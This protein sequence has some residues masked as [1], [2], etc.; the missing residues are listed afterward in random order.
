MD[1]QRLRALLQSFSGNAATDTRAVAP[2][3]ILV[4][5]GTI[6]R[7]EIQDANR[8]GIW[9]GIATQAF[10]AAIT[11]FFIGHF[12]VRRL[13]RGLWLRVLVVTIYF[14]LVEATRGVV[15][16]YLATT[17]EPY[18]EPNWPYAIVAGGV[19]GIVLFG[20][21]S[22]ILNDA[23]DY[24]DRLAQIL[25]VRSQ[26]E[27][28][29][30]NSQAAIQTKRLELSSRITSAIEDALQKV[31]SMAKPSKE[32]AMSFAN[33][34]I[35]I[36][37]EVVRPL[38]HQ[39][40]QG[41]GLPEITS[42]Q[43]RAKVKLSRVV[44]LV[45][46]TAP[47]RAWP[48]ALITLMLSWPSVLF[49][50]SK[51]LNVAL[52]IVIVV[53]WA[54]FWF[55]L[56]NRYLLPLIRKIRAIFRW[57]LFLVAIAL[58]PAFPITF[59]LVADERDLPEVAGFVSY[60]IILAIVLVG[61]LAIYPALEKARNELIGE[62]ALANQ[63]LAWHL[64]RL[65]SV[66]RIEEKNLARKLHKDVQGTLVASALRLQQALE[67]RRNPKAAIEKI[68]RDVALAVEQLSQSETPLDLKKFV[69]NLNAGWKPVFEI[70]IRVEKTLLNQINRDPICLAT[71]SDL[72]GEF[73]TNSVKHGASSKGAVEITLVRDDVMRAT[74]ENNGKPL[75]EKFKSGLGT[76]LALAQV[77][78]AGYESRETGVRF[79]A[80]L[81]IAT[82]KV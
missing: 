21:A 39:V 51:P 65:G 32:D 27:K 34:L 42:Q 20:I 19:T 55:E 60:L 80:D 58:M 54:A 24:R 79:T 33:G 64:A 11:V 31:L 56:L 23:N 75:P 36:S 6:F 48:F 72:L 40:Y 7:Q 28:A 46:V 71:I 70:E 77:I 12:L 78:N 63:S 49:V 69:R 57:P 61:A 82:A 17:V 38:S 8:L 52:S 41:I 18:P 29:I 16:E 37:E 25:E 26:T 45:P 53:V 9:I 13:K 4:S 22:I 43:T 14:F 59:F 81:A 5:F 74:F 3:L 10:L 68:R 2:A 50:A 1:Y 76:Q 67:K 30:E 47:F 15:I 62:A 35:Q 44:E 66:L 73:A